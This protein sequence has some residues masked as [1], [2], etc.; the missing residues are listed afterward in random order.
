MTV[1]GLLI[2]TAL[3][4]AFLAMDAGAFDGRYRGAGWQQAI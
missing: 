3:V 2:L 4:G 1:R